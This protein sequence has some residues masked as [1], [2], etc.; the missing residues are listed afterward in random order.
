MNQNPD[1]TSNCLEFLRETTER[2]AQAEALAQA[3]N[4]RITVAV[5]EGYLLL[6]AQCQRLVCGHGLRDGP[7]APGMA[8]YNGHP[9]RMLNQPGIIMAIAQGAA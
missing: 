3:D 5:T 6:L 1:G 4:Q 8:H 2:I 7:T 9:L